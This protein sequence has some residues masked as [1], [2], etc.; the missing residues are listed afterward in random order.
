MTSLAREG[1]RRLRD[2]GVETLADALRRYARRRRREVPKALAARSRHLRHRYR[3]GAAAPEPYRLVSVDPTSVDHVLAPRFQRERSEW[4]AHLV[5][6]EWD[7]RTADR[8]LTYATDF[9]P[10]DGDRALVRF[11]DYTFYRSLRA[12]FE[13]GR[14]WP[15]TE[16]YR[17]LVETDHSDVRYETEAAVDERLQRLEEIY[18]DMRESGYRT[19]AELGR[20]DE[21]YSLAPPRHHEVLVNVGRDGELILDD[22]RHRFCLA[23]ILGLDSILVR[24]FVRHPEW[25]ARRVEVAS[26]SDPDDPAHLDHP[27]LRDL[28]SN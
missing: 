26:G 11:E 1:V 28:R 14:P 9:E 25:Q 27:D 15:E 10:W 2:G 12:H 3:Y 4:A 16:L 17:W 23:R 6:G 7:Q 18:A 5:D 24:V 13:D 19:Q 21:F 22:G 8:S 20:D